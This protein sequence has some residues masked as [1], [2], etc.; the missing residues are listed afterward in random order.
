MMSWLREKSQ[1]YP[2]YYPYLG[3]VTSFLCHSVP[4][5]RPRHSILP[6]VVWPKVLKTM[7]DGLK[8]FFRD[9]LCNFFGN[10]QAF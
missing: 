10:S 5:P 6:G 9:T 7:T 8:T 1:H 3:V 2:Y 4:G